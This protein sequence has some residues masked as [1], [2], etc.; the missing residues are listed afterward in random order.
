MWFKSL[1]L[2][3]RTKYWLESLWLWARGME[4]TCRKPWPGR[5]KPMLVKHKRH[6]RIP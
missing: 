6:R 1:H 4:Q 5:G 2:I 3:Q